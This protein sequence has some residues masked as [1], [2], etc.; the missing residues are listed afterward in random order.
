MDFESLVSAKE[1]E[2]IQNNLF[3]LRTH[4]ETVEYQ[5]K[6]KN[7]A[8]KYSLNEEDI[9]KGIKEN[10]IIAS[11]FCKDPSKQNFTEKLVSEILGVKALP[12]SG[13]NCIRFD[14]KGEI[15]SFKRVDSSKSADFLINNVYITQKYTRGAGGAQDNQYNDV[16]DFL[17]KGS[18][19]HKCAAILD[20]SFW[21]T[22]REELVNYFKDNHNVKILSMDDVI[23]GGF[24]FE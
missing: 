23:N 13:K 14:T 7:Y 9:V 21:E 18:K 19:Q 17:I 15:H 8:K 16:V 24:N 6:I 1:K 10:D 11:F 22:K 5:T 12:Q 3:H 4:Y 2:L 20:G